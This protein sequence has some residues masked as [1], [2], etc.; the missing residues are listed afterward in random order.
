MSATERSLDE[1]EARANLVFSLG[2]ELR[3]KIINLA[4]E[5]SPSA[6]FGLAEAVLVNSGYVAREAEELAKAARWLAVIK[7]D[8]PESFESVVAK[9]L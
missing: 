2:G 8:Y 9:E 6:T 4:R 5:R 1:L 3:R 7:R